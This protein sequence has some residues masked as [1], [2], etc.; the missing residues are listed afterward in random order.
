MLE[1]E[2]QPDVVSSTAAI[3]AYQQCS[4]WNMALQ[5]FDDFPRAQLKPDLRSFH[6][7]LRALADGQ[8]CGMNALQLLQSIDST[9]LQ[10]TPL[11][12]DIA[13][14]SCESSGQWQEERETK[15]H[16]LKAVRS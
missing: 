12:Y 4:Q 5:V 7:T 15:K 8:H 2:I 1:A 14:C 9:R 11:T 16:M 6:A 3:I 13:I 10:L